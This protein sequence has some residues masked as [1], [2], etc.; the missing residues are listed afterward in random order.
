M[1]DSLGDRMKS[2]YKRYMP[3]SK[4]QLKEKYGK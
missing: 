1:K 2:N 4:E 3:L